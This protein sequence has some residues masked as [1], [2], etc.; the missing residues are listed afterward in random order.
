MT[1]RWFRLLSI[2]VLVILGLGSVLWLLDTLVRLHTWL[3]VGSPLLAN[4]VMLMVI[5]IALVCLSI[6]GYYIYLFVR[7]KRR[8]VPRPSLRTSRE[9]ADA[10][11]QAL[12][13][14]V[15][16]IQD[17][18]ARQALRERTRN[19]AQNLH[20]RE[21]RIVVFGVGSAGKT[22]L[23]NTLMGQWVGA[24]GAPMGTT[25]A[26][27]TYRLPLES[28]HR[29]LWITDT[30]GLLEPGVAGTLRE[31][32]ARQLA[33][34]ADLL[35][36]VVD[37]DLRQSEYQVLETL[38]RMGKRMLVVF[39]KADRYPD[40]E[41][42]QILT[43]LRSRLEWLVAAEDVVAIAAQ[44]QPL[45][46]PQGELVYP[47]PDIWTLLDRL[48]TVIR[49]EGDDLIAD[50][51]LL[52]SR[53]LGDEARQIIE[54][55]RLAQANA[56]VDRFQWVGAGVVA[57]MPLPVVDLLA[58]AAINAQMVVEIGRVYQC[59]VSLEEGK[60]LA[61]SLAKTLTSLGIVKGVLELLSIGL[62]T[63]LATVLAGRAL[64][65]VSAAYLT[66]IA[67]KSFIDYFQQQQDWGDGGMAEVVERQFQLNRRDEFVRLFL[68]DAIAKVVTPLK[69][70][71]LESELD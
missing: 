42:P 12:D 61:L 28:I 63:N 3:A 17:E 71:F 33:T 4:I 51:I 62:Q 46:L 50:N 27:T 54:A 59:E 24:V 67:G 22:S 16:Q 65:G 48:V 18:V 20:R 55:Q 30:P 40:E 8:R 56:V 53:K 21:F 52:Q 60:A 64:Q 31:Q 69:Q 29:E 36:F 9:A 39:N 32:Q 34:E 23:V 2:A 47:E 14:Q 6:I 41:W 13:E 68:Q 7:P 35:L 49:L 25:Q 66:R 58:T 57:A 70:T 43:R 44:P 45:L 11:L 19:V 10:T 37:D 26:S 5:A 38:V 15:A 1:A